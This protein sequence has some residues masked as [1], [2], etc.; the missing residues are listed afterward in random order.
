MPSKEAPAAPRIPAHVC[1]CSAGALTIGNGHTVVFGGQTWS[2]SPHYFC[3]RCEG[4]E[5]RSPLRATV[6]S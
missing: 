1:T 2:N 4:R 5:V 6:A 3:A